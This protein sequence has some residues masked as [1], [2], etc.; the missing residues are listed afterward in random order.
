MG[1]LK[2]DEQ[3]R[4]EGMAYAL[5][6]AEKEGIEGLREELERRNATGIPM[7][8][9][10]A[11]LHKFSQAVKHNVVFYVS[12]LARGV[13]V[14]KFDFDADQLKQFNEAFNFRADCLSE[15]YTTWQDQIDT[16]N[17]E[18]GLDIVDEGASTTVKISKK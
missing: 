14:D 2:K 4:R 1:N 3:L 17:E 15:D 11:E 5:R 9:S 13:L 8:V 16:L 12:V 10:N 6:V 18:I 7:S